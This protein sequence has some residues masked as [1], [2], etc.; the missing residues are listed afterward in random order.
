MKIVVFDLDETLGHFTDIYMFYEYF[1]MIQNGL[2]TKTFKELFD[3]FPDLIRPNLINVLNYIKRQCKQ[4]T[5]DGVV[6]YT[7][8]HAGSKWV[9]H[10]LD[11]LNNKINYKLFNKTILS[12]KQHGLLNEVCRSS[13][14]KCMTDFR[15]CTGLPLDTNICYIDDVYY[16]QMDNVGV[17]YI[18]IKPFIHKIDMETMISRVSSSTYFQ[19][20]IKN[21]TNFRKDLLSKGVH[22][23][24][25]SKTYKEDKEIGIILLQYI[26]DFFQ[27]SALHTRK[28][29]HKQS[30]STTRKRR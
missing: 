15:R 24:S 17:Y 21:M 4:R 29:K 20:F 13:R 18:C 8:N 30:S 10:I 28:Q 12:F 27:Q 14:L 22:N 19:K 7:N 5:C 2:S 16:P 25:S 11:Y 1:L 6:V 26:K 9:N 23:S 3:L